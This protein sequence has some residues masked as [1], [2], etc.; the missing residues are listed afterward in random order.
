M[1][2]SLFNTLSRSVQEFA[3]LDPAGKKVGMY[4]C[5]PTVYD[6]AHIG[7]WRTFVFADLVRRYLQFKGYAVNHVMNITDVEDKIIKRVRETNSTLRDV[8][9]KYEAAFL[10]DLKTLNCLEPHQKPRATEHMPEI[11]ALIEK[12]LA[13]GIAYKANDGSVY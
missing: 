10:E 6:F 3:P 9:G 2:L 4:C 8:T 12:L 11:I 1:G 5:G 13:R 7:N